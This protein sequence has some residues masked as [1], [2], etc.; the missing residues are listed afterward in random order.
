MQ[1]FL[2]YVLSLVAFCATGVVGCHCH[3][4]RNP[5][6]A[7]MCALGCTVWT[8]LMIYSLFTWLVP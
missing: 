7:V 6:L 5:W 1:P 3:T 8:A 2:L 4:K